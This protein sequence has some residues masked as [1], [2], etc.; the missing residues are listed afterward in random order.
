M[1]SSLEIAALAN[2]HARLWTSANVHRVSSIV[3]QS[4]EQGAIAME[5]LESILVR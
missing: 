2:T 5:G 4:H 3:Q 1:R